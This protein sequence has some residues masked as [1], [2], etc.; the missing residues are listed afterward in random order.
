MNALLAGLKKRHISL[1][2]RPILIHTAG[3]G[4]LFEPRLHTLQHR[5]HH[6]LGLVCQLSRRRLA[7]R[8]RYVATTTLMPLRR[9]SLLPHHNVMLILP[10]SRLTKRV[11]RNGICR[12]LRFILIPLMCRICENIY[13]PPEQDLGYCQKSSRG[14]WHHEPIL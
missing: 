13:Y 10:L 4:M 9:F 5:S 8:T 6:S 2:D 11:R 7:V 3:T 12:S 14:R 1:G